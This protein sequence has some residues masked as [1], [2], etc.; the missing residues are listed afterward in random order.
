[1][2]HPR[3]TRAAWRESPS[4]AATP[5]LPPR[6]AQFRLELRLLAE[7]A[8]YYIPLPRS[9]WEHAFA[10]A[11][12]ILFYAYQLAVISAAIQIGLALPMAI[13]FH[14]ISLTGISANILVVPLLGLVVPLGFLAILTMWHAARGDRRMAAHASEHIAEWHTRLEPDWRVLAPPLWLG[15]FFHRRAH[16]AGLCDAPVASM[17]AGR[18]GGRSGALRV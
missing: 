11:A 14:R 6:V 2:A 17:V 5:R 7:T 9:W 15:D 10:I 8:S 18:A 13:Y 12:R 1:M 4:L 16:S 3:F